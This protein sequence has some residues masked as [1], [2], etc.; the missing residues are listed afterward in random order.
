MST[1]DLVAVGVRTDY[2]Y[3]D[4]S[5]TTKQAIPTTMN[6]KYRLAIQN[7]TGGMQT[8]TFPPTAGLNGVLLVLQLPNIA[9][10]GDGL[11]GSRFCSCNS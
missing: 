6:T 7:L 11:S 8:F 5:E 1:Q 2:F 4:P 3:P 9:A 10:P